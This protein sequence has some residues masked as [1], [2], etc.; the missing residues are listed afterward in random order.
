MIWFLLPI[1]YLA[2]G[3]LCGRAFHKEGDDAITSLITILA[4]PLAL[5]ITAFSATIDGL[6]WLVSVP[7]PRPREIR[8]RRRE[9]GQARIAELEAEVDRLAK[10]QDGDR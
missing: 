5:V 2:I 1:A 7:L 9:R 10:Q 8:Q 6:H 4:W 3:V